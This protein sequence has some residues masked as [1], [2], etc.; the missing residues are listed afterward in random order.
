MMDWSPFWISLKVSGWSTLFAIA[1]GLPIAFGI[2]RRQFPGRTAI[3]G[4]TNLPLVMPPTKHGYAILDKLGERSPVS[5][6]WRHVTGHPLGLTFTWHGAVVAACVA[7]IPLFISQA[8]VSIGAIDQDV[9]DAARSD[10]AGQFTLAARIMAP[11][12]LPGL[13]AGAARV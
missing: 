2:A 12:A 3:V 11:L 5:Q 9:I 10:G 4:L 1:V 7:S 6:F 13:L 8:R